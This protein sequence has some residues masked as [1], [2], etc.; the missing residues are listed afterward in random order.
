[1]SDEIGDAAVS[2]VA[3]KQTEAGAAVS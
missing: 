1:M 2:S 3:A